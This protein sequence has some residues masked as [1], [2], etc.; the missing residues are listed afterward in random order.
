MCGVHRHSQDGSGHRQGNGGGVSLPY[1]TMYPSDFDADETVRVMSFAEK[2]LY[3]VLLN[4]AWVNDGLPEDPA[5]VA[6]VAGAGAEEFA[7]LWPGV[8]ACF[9]IADG[10]RRNAR[11]ERERSKATTKVN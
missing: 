11:Q 6:R 4:H 9:P 7:L 5:R 3:L 2:G 1:Y 8:Q 10:R